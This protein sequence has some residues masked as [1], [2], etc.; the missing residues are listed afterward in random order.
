MSVTTNTPVQGPAHGTIAAVLANRNFVL[1][2]SGMMISNTGSWMQTVI[3]PAYIDQRTESGLW[4]GLF[5]FALLGPVLLLSVPGGVLADRFPSKPWLVSMQLVQMVMTVVI[6]VMISRHAGLL[7]IL[8]AQLLAGVGN[9]LNNPAMQGVLP[10]MVDPRDIGGVVSLNSVGINGSRVIGPI[11]AA[12][13]MA[14]G[15]TTSEVLLANAASFLV[16]IA[17][18]VLARFPP[19]ERA[20]ESR[21]WANVTHGLRLAVERSVLGR[22]LAGM[23]IFSFFC[24]P[25]VGLFATITR[26]SLRLDSSTAT[27]KWLYATWGFGALCGAL[28]LGTVLSQV[29]K[30]RLI[31][32]TLIGFAASLGAFGLLRSVVPAFPVAFVLGWFYFAMATAKLTVIQHNLHSFERARVMALW[33]MAFGGMVAIGNL[34]FGPVVDALGTR[35]VMLMGVAVALWL[36]WWCD[37]PHRNV[38]FLADEAPASGSVHQP[39]GDTFEARHPAALDQDGVAAGD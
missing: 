15:V 22:L 19:H 13:L 14:R 2:W 27:Y 33:F 12:V 36:S 9:A 5:T 38:R 23:A 28:T 20:T 4:V 3:L 31:R 24:L 18:I 8:G 32:P 35:A 6:A 1:L 30:A 25:W 10:N 39:V 7:W 21:G 34:A 16:V 26:L 29:D 11:I 17:A 37:V